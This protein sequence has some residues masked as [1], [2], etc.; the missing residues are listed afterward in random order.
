MTPAHRGGG[1]AE[2]VCSN[3]LKALRLDSAAGLLKEELRRMGSQLLPLAEQAAVPAGG[4]LAVDRSVFSS[5]VEEKVRS[6]ALIEVV[7]GEVADIPAQG[8]VVVA[9]G[10]LCSPA[11]STCIEG[12][13]GGQLLVFFD[14]AAPIVDAS[15]LDR[16]KVFAESRYDR[17]E[18]ARRP[19]PPYGPGCATRRSSTK[20]A[21]GRA[22]Y[23]AGF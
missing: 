22:G 17:G 12:R 15:T 2:L 19:E 8:P 13:V 3:S 5:L 9:A 11:L 4:A 21:G 23:P 6:N 20:L 14:A 16:K 7:L 10:P 18:G 1:L